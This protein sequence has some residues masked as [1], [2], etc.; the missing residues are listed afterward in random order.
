MSEAKATLSERMRE[1]ADARRIWDPPEM[2]TTQWFN[3]LLRRYADEV[4]QL[5]AELIRAKAN[6]RV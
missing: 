5:E 4:E 3:G 6:Q 1:R 2:Y